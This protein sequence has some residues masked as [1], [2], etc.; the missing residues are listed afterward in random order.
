MPQKFKLYVR[1]NEQRVK[2]NSIGASNTLVSPYNEVAVQTEPQAASDRIDAAVQT[3]KPNL[4]TAVIVQTYLQPL[5]IADIEMQTEVEMM[6][7]NEV[8][9]AD[10]GDIGACEGEAISDE[11]VCEGNNDKKYGPL[12]A[13]HKGVFLNVKGMC[14]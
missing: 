8:C 14:Y 6:A 11:C 3:D 9:A 1:K 7:A 5:D 10:V 12:V 13:K 4:E 2:M